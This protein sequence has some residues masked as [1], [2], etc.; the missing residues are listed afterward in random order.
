MT[1]AADPDLVMFAFTAEVGSKSEGALNLLASWT[2]T[3]DEPIAADTS[4]RDATDEYQ[5]PLSSSD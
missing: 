5:K 2:A 4:D 1:L 3:R